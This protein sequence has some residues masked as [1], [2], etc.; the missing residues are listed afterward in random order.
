MSEQKLQILKIKSRGKF[1]DFLL[2]HLNKKYSLLWLW[3]IFLFEIILILPLDLVI[4]FYTLQNKTRHSLVAISAALCSTISAGVG[5]SIG[6][7][8]FQR[9]DWLI[10]KF[11]S[12]S[13]FSKTAGLY[14]FWEKGI[15]FFGS[16]LPMPF[17]LITVSA[18]VYHASFFNFLLL[19]FIARCIRF[20]TISLIS[21][22]LE[23]KMF[24]VME[25]YSRTFAICSALIPLFIFGLWILK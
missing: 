3:L 4:I 22:R 14:Q 17:K 23:S 15:I 6:Y 10:F 7:F 20:L 12:P 9:L 11:I 25:K 2:K 24:D 1:V 13:Q 18:G 16:L 8:A 5:Y 21:I 19:I